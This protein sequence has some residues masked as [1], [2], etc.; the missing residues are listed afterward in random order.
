MSEQNEILARRY[1]LE[2]MNQANWKTLYEILSPDFVFTLPTHPEPYRTPDGF[3]QLVTM[4]H[5]AF[6]D[7]YI[8]IRDMM[9]DGDTVV[10]RWWG[11]GRHT[12]GPLRT[13]AG[14][15]QASGRRFDIDGITWHTIRD[16]KI[17]EGI[18]HEDTVG[19]MAQLGALPLPPDP[20]PPLAPG[21]A[22]RL[23]ARYFGEIMNQGKLEVVPQILHPKF[24]FSIPTLPE[25]VTGYDGFTGFVTGLRT[26]FPDLKFEVLREMATSTRV[27]SRW[28]FTGTH[29]GPFLGAPPTGRSIEDLGIDIFQISGGKILTVNVNEDDFGLMR[30]LGLFGPS[31]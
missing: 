8:D 2:I 3:K 29:R 1:F 27:A 28:R 30:Q 6:P 9:S 21:D 12:G 24:S 26:A 22:R 5:G 10:T 20:R 18:G 31:R 17:V 11:G 4:L 14:D 19:L 16:G 23:V 25:P 15:L 7:F 13:T